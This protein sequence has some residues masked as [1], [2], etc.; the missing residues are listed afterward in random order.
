MDRPLNILVVDDDIPLTLFIS[1]VLSGEGHRVL[2]AP[3]LIKA[4]M[5]MRSER[6]D[7]AI[8]DLVIPGSDGSDIIKELKRSDPSIYGVLIS[9]YYNQSFDNYK[10]LVGADEVI[11]KPVT[12]ET[13]I[14]IIRRRNNNAA[15]MEK[16]V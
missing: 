3:S 15:Q 8:V 14:E 12:K 7:I 1:K 10:V 11:G 16:A 4:Q 2:T 5:I 13:L 6:I 9:G